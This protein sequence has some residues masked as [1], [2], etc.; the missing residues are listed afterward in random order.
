MMASIRLFEL[1]GPT[2]QRMFLRADLQ[3]VIDLG[4]ILVKSMPRV[5]LR[6]TDQVLLAHLSLG[7]RKTIFDVRLFM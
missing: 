6:V 3:L 4:L 1:R 2:S 7:R 5:L